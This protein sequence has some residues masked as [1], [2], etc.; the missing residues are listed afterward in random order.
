MNIGREIKIWLIL[1]KILATFFFFFVIKARS[2]YPRCTAAY[3]LI[4]RPLAPPPSVILDVPIFASKRLHLLTT[5][6][7]LAAKGGTV[8]KNVGR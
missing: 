1:A 5:R 4:V 8:G 2:I 3:G 6:E 7:I